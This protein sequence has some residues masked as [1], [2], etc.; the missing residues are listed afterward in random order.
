M[1]ETRNLTK[2]T[3]SL[4]NSVVACG[5]ALVMV[6]TLVAQT[7]DQTSAK[8]V[9]IKGEAR[10]STGNNVWQPLRL[11][12]IVRPGTLI[13]TASNS[14]INLALGG[15]GTTP[16]AQAGAPT[17]MLSYRA[18]AEQNIMRLWDNTLV[19]IDRLTETHTG[20]DV[21]TET[22]LD[23]KAGRITGT[24]KKMSAA[25]K[26]EI[27]IPNGVAGIR[28]TVY[29]ITADGVIKIL[30]G[31]AVMAYPG[32]DGSPA[33]QVI[34]GMQQFDVRTG[35]LSAL[36]NS[37]QTGLGDV[38]NQLQVGLAPAA[39]P[40]SANMSLIYLSPH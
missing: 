13:Q 14:Q 1:K 33:T 24:V 2:V 30:S 40:V 21:V 19:G 10:Y 16:V 9:R 38:V 36:P 32:P 35:V 7:T 31:S 11:G 6:S 3:Q 34:M 29:D 39:I 17:S 26:Y 18:S 20:A 27:K 23:L 8:V 5:V 25:S 22:Q 37:D 15:E 28:G 12:D 4:L